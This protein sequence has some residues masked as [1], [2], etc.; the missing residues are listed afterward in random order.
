MM[1]IWTMDITPLYLQKEICMETYTF[2]KNSYTT[3]I[4][5]EKHAYI[6]QKRFLRNEITSR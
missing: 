5:I 1:M 6:E 3:Y 4:Y 2:T